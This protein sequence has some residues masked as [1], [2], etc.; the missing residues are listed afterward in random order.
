MDDIDTF[1]CG[2]IEDLMNEYHV[3]ETD[4]AQNLKVHT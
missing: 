2:G 4:N 1:N 3:F